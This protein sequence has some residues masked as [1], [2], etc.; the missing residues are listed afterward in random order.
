MA[1]NDKYKEK[2]EL[3]RFMV[4][5]DSNVMY[6]WLLYMYTCIHFEGP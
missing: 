4:G 1:S 5:V 3:G 6:G 2:D